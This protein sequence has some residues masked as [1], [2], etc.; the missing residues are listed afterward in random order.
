MAEATLAAPA[1]VPLLQQRPFRSLQ[2]SRFANRLAQNSLNFALVLLIVDETQRA[3][4]SSLLVLALVIPGTVAGIIAGTA[5]D[6]FPKRLISFTANVLRAGA[7]V[8]FI[9]R[10]GDVPSFF[11]TAVVLAT[12]AQFVGSADGAIL[13]AIVARDSLARANAIGHA[14]GG[15]AQLVGFAILAPLALRVFDSPDTLFAIGAVLFLIAAGYSVAIGRVPSAN[16]MEVGGRHE[17]PWWSTGW[18]EMRRDPRVWHAAVELT[19]ISAALIILGGL[20][21]TFI[22]DTLDLP[23]EVGAL[24]LTPAA[25]GV[26]LGLRIAGFLAHR[27]PHVFLSTGGFISFAILLGLVTYTNELAS[28]LG[29]FGLFSW[30]NSVEI[31]QFDGGGV[32]AMVIVVPLGFAYALVAVAAQTAINDLVPLHLQ[33]RVLAAQ[34]A[35]AA[36]AASVPV[37]VAGALSDAVGVTPV[38]TLLAIGTGIVAVASLQSRRATR[39]RPQGVR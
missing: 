20:I 28:F 13:P 37:L 36:L 6:S 31:G 38:L 30:L 10:G 3:F 21:P 27:I 32:M 25:I 35:M 5:A 22:Q 16:R 18:R 17:G 8:L 14:V 39:D 2:F 4:M 9:L 19:V 34:G 26:A 33:G 24:I 23:V 15:V 12:L 11:V 1:P 7:C 29:G